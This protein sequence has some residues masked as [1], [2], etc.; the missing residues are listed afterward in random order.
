MEL[1]WVNPSRAGPNLPRLDPPFAVC[2]AGEAQGG[3]Q[4]TLNFHLP[5]LQGPKFTPRDYPC[6]VSVDSFPVAC[7]EL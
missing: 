5:M 1:G 7:L 3:P 2:K 4:D 6:P